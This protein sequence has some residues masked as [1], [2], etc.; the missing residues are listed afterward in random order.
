[1]S[2]KSVVEPVRILHFMGKQFSATTMTVEKKIGVI[3]GVVSIWLLGIL[4]NRLCAPQCGT[5][6][7]C[8]RGTLL[9]VERSL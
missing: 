9:E 2:P 6:T 7:I 3:G 4:Q 5:G 1:M 8:C